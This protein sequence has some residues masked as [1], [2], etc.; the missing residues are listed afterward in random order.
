M[1]GVWVSDH[2][3]AVAPDGTVSG[4]LEPLVLLAALARRDVADRARDARARRHDAEPGA[5]RAFGSRARLRAG[6]SSASAPAGTS[7]SIARSASRFP[8]TGSGSR[9][10]RRR[11]RRCTGSRPT[12]RRSSQAGRGARLL[13]LAARHADVWNVSWD[14]PPDGFAQLS[15]MLGRG[16]RSRGRDPSSIRRSVGLTVLVGARRPRHRCR[17]G[18]APR[19]GARS[20]R[21]SIETRSPTR[22]SPAPRRDARSGSLPTKRTRWWSRCC[23]ATIRRCWISSRPRSRRSSEG[24]G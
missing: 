17:G 22:S 23:C 7:P 4:A 24:R 6:S 1:D 16:M 9:A 8:A 11:S 12:G 5:G 2:P 19:E 20:Y 21:A 10:S 3:F 14:A 15:R 13:E 18:A